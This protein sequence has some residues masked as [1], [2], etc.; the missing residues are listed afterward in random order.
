MY[1]K[2]LLSACLFITAVGVF[3]Q[4]KMQE[5]HDFVYKTV[6]GHN[7]MATAYLPESN[8][9]LPVLIYFH[10]GGFMFGNR[11]QGLEE[12][13]KEK[14]LAAGIAVVSADYRLAP[15]TKLEEILRDASD[16]V[17]WV[18][19][20]GNRKFNIDT[21]RIAVAGGSAGGYLALSTGLDPQFTPNAIVVVSSPTEFSTTG[22]QTGNLRLLQHI[23][24]DS[25]VSHGDYGS[26]MDLWRYLGKNGLAL[27][28]IFGFDPVKEPR[29]LERYLL[30]HRIKSGYP[31]T[32]I[33]HA[34]NDHLVKFD[35]AKAFYSF[36]QEKEIPSKLYAVENGHSSDLINRYPDAVDAIIA[37]LT[38][39]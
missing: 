7:I 9:K 5:K 17:R 22:I 33:V 34:K 14:L 8:G 4:E 25:V 2:W 10:G 37:F 11:V 18:K 20:Y 27:Y 23:K 35:E 15:E 30:T 24:K 13:L 38:S 31:P 26:R 36:L 1:R 29:K 12:T 3:S 6:A 28:E 39:L 21:N 32:L 16:A 19:T